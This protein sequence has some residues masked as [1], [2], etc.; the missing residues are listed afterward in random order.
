MWTQIDIPRRLGYLAI[1]R[2]CQAIG[3]LIRLF[4][5]FQPESMSPHGD[6]YR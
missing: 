6:L 1:P 3:A 4:L 5:I 2:L